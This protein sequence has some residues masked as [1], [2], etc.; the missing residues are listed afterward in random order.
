M[1]LCHYRVR[2]LVRELV[3][4]CKQDETPKLAHQVAE[5]AVRI[6]KHYPDSGSKVAEGLKKFFVSLIT[7]QKSRETMEAIVDPKCTCE[8]AG[9]KSVSNNYQA[10]TRCRPLQATAACCRPLKPAAGR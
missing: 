2:K 10:E 1:V 4:L 8:E 7:D 5:Q 3:A 6:A 9:E